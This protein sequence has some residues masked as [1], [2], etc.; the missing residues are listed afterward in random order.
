MAVGAFAGLVDGFTRGYG[1]SRQWARED[2]DAKARADERAWRNEQRERERRDQADQDAIGAALKGVKRNVPTYGG[3]IEDSEMYGPLAGDLQ[4]T[5]RS[6]RDILADQAR[7]I[8]GIGGLRGAQLGLQF[9]QGV[10]ALDATQEQRRRQALADVRQAEIDRQAGIDR[11]ARRAREAVADRQTRVLEGL[12][13]ARMLLANAGN[14]P[15][16]L[17]AVAQLM[18][19][20]YEGVPDGRQLVLN[21]G[22]M[23]VATPDQK[24][25]P[26][27]EPVPINRQN[28]ESALEY[29]E[30]YLDPNWATRSKVDIEAQN[31]DFMQGYYRDKLGL[32]TRQ[33][34]AQVRG[35]MF[36]R[37]PSAADVF[38]PIGLSDDGT[39]ILGRQG[40][41]IREVPVPA[42]Y[43]GLFPRVTGAKPERD[44]VQKAWLDAES[45][46]I[47]GGY[48]PDEIRQQQTAFFARRGFA[49]PEAEAALR[50]GID[51]STK[52]PLTPADIAEFNR[53]FPQSAVN[54]EELSWAKR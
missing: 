46:L 14:D 27:F 18:Q 20:T 39:R 45:K 3:S 2:E 49:P 43:K 19:G 23:G 50:S 32:D 25:V 33:F 36:T 29:A 26:G 47:A 17:G 35:G 37:P 42:G 11:D 5:Q 8:A 53:R 22:A 13:N 51:P 16:R 31:K 15:A 1:L 44:A 12:R 40:G 52:K 10:D 48:K 34:E 4:T 21:N 41:G 38:T 54:P 6:Q 28:L 9:Q 7:A 24:W 30:R